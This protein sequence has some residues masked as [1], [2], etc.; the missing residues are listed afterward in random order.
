MKR[1]NQF[2]LIGVIVII[3]FIFLIDKL[4]NLRSPISEKHIGVK[5]EI[6]N[7][8]SVENNP[9]DLR[10]NFLRPLLEYNIVQKKRK[11]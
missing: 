10:E 5:F 11:Q 4:L 9:A 3:I 2:I 1:K 7:C 8:S 6:H